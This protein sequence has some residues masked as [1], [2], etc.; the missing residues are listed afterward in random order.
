[1]LAVGLPKAG[2]KSFV[3]PDSIVLSQCSNPIQYCS[4]FCYSHSIKAKYK[5]I[6]LARTHKWDKHHVP[7]LS[8]FT[9][10]Q[11]PTGSH[12]GMHSPLWHETN[13]SS[14]CRAA[15]L[16][17]VL[18][19]HSDKPSPA[20]K[21]TEPDKGSNLTKAAASAASDEQRQ[22]DA[23]QGADPLL[24]ITGVLGHTFLLQEETTRFN[25]AG[26]LLSEIAT[27]YN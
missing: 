26:G 4:V 9:E 13:L 23:F 20:F 6:T 24:H 2:V 16:P 25:I 14:N 17:S 10:D 18:E 1:M 11:Q 19:R 21:E 27:F 12:Y 5:V 15:H 8:P 3:L 7:F 22:W